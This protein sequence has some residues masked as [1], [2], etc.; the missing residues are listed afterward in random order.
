MQMAAE[1]ATSQAVWAILCIGLCIVVLKGL[2]DD[3]ASREAKLTALYEASRQE[4]KEREQRLMEHLDRSN[5]VQV[6]TAKT[7]VSIQQ[8]QQDVLVTVRGFDVRLDDVERTLKGGGEY[9]RQ[10]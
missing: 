8:S 5:E 6:E 4:S 3:S 9:E 10:N 1:I 2:R 7:L